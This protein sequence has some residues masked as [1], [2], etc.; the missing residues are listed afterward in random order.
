MLAFLEQESRDFF[1][2]ILIAV[3]GWSPPLDVLQTQGNSLIRFIA[4]TD[5][6]GQEKLTLSA[7]IKYKCNGQNSELKGERDLFPL[8]SF[9][10]VSI[11]TQTF[12][13]LR[14]NKWCCALKL[15]MYVSVPVLPSGSS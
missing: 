7:D 2:Q 1:P 13:E 10:S 6:E 9:P 3:A 4:F 14:R 5:F 15:A 11:L 8:F 12:T